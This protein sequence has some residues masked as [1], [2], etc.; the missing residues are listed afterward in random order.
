MNHTADEH[1]YVSRPYCRA[2][3]YAGRVACCPLVSDGEYANGTVG[4]TEG[5]VLDRCITLS[6]RRGK[7]NKL[8]RRRRAGVKEETAHGE[9]VGGSKKYQARGWFSSTFSQCFYT[10]GR[11]TER[12]SSLV[13]PASTISKV[14]CRGSRR[15]R[16][17][18]E[19]RKLL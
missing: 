7:R 13:K 1:K 9:S 2:E 12:A 6:T 19:K 18:N 10:V 17:C 14:H 4:R 15:N 11:V 3:M 16:K 8:K 5:R